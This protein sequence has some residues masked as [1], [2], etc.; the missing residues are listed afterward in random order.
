[1]VFAKF[2]SEWSGLA[3]MLRIDQF[4]SERFRLTAM[5]KIDQVCIWMIRIDSNAK[6]LTSLQQNDPDWQQ[7]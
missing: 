6:K 5:Q 7:C 4:A 2:A 1:M 3:A